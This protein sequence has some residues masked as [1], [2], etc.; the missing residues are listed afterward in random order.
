[1][2]SQFLQI[3]RASD[4]GVHIPGHEVPPSPIF[5]FLGA[6]TSLNHFVP[7]NTFQEGV[8]GVGDGLF[9]FEGLQLR[10]AIG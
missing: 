8:L 10:K 2:Q 6:E 9:D 7:A 1:M 3:R 4:N 5:I